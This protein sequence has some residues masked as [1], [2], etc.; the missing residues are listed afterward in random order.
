MSGGRF[1][2]FRKGRKRFFENWSI[3]RS[4]TVDAPTTIQ[5]LDYTKA[6]GIWNLKSTMQF[7]KVQSGGGGSLSTI[8]Y[9][10][11]TGSMQS[12]SSTT[13]TVSISASAQAGDLAVLEIGLDSSGAS[14]TTPTGWTLAGNG[15]TSEYPRMFCFVKILDATDISTGSVSVT[16]S[17]I[18]SMNLLSI[19]R[20][21][22]ITSFTTSNFAND[23]GAA[24]LSTSLATT[25]VSAPTIA[26]AFLVGRTT[27]SPTMTWSTADALITDTTTGGTRTM[28]YTIYQSGATPASHSMT[29]NDTGRQSM[30]CFYID[31]Q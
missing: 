10:D 26:I 7:P 12:T 22:T 13:A 29:S 11:T 24:S 8:S 20:A 31:L 25:G 28:G 21:G 18:P 9:V 16:T 19:F 15:N 3:M 4:E 6:K 30:S 5:D 2:G 1:G 14:A 27:Q 23:K 17:N